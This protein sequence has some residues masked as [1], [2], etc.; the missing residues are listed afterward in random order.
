MQQRR[1]KQIA[2]GAFVFA[3]LGAVLLFVGIVTDAPG[4]RMIVSPKHP[5]LENGKGGVEPGLHRLPWGGWEGCTGDLYGVCP[6]GYMAGY[7]AL[8]S[9]DART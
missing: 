8:R 4:Q 9:D 7:D 5:N 6:S 1:R 2:S 3:G